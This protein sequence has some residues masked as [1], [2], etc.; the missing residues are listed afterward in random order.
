MITKVLIF[1]V[2]LEIMDR[3]I[4]F[5]YGGFN[6]RSDYESALQCAAEMVRNHYKETGALGECFAVVYDKL[7]RSRVVVWLTDEL[8]VKYRKLF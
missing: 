1:A 8:M 6:G 3:Y 7:N 4:I 2:T 5:C